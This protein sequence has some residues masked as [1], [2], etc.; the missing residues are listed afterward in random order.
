[1]RREDRGP[2]AAV[3]L[4]IVAVV[5]VALLAGSNGAPPTTTSAPAPT[6]PTV[7]A[8]PTTPTPPS[9]EEFGA[10]VNR[11]FNDR[12]Y[13]AAQI[14]AQLSAL[15]AA[16]ATVARS[17]ALWEASEP[18]PP[19]NG[20]HRFDW[21]F[22][23]QLAEAL[24]RRS[25]RWLPI[26][27]YTAP[28]DQSLPGRDHSPPRSAADYAAYAFA[29]AARYGSS[30]SFWR[31][32]PELPNLAVEQYEIWN[33]PDNPVFWVPAPD[34][35]R[36]ARLYAAAAAAIHAADPK[37][38]VLVGGLT[39]PSTFLPAMLAADP[40]L[41]LRIGGVAI[42]PYGAT[43]ALVLSNL[44][45]ARHVLDSLGMAL[46]PLYVTE[47]G[48]TTS[49]PGALDGAPERLR[50]GYIEQTL[51]ALG[52]SGCGLAAAILYTWVAPERD[53]RDAQDW[54]GVS[55]PRDPGHGPDVAAFQAGLQQAAQTGPQA[56]C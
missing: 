2:I 11:L 41:R 14:D 43:P 46:T 47:F 50:P 18:T 51:T 4:L 12:V 29:F 9:S 17:D 44:A 53:L 15:H 24:A 16:G 13:S 32:H 52:H 27:D 49:P 7:P 35:A 33:Q 8:V 54:F 3:A 23:D 56:S 45:T 26:L 28:W 30:G 1:V 22:D 40:S 55:P 20:L 6:V 37:G 5:V 38:Q 10:S 21:G 19:V 42:H 39:S 34:P 36:Y 25:L 31:A 48:W